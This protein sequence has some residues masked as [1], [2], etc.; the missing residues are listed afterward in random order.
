MQGR[1]NLGRML[2]EAKTISDEA[3]GVEEEEEEEE[4][5]DVM[6]ELLQPSPNQSLSVRPGSARRLRLCRQASVCLCKS[7]FVAWRVRS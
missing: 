7:V 5:E 2:L 3:P 4:E 6:R 1:G